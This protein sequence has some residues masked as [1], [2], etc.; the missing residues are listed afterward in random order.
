MRGAGRGEVRGARRAAA[1]A[2]ARG[3]L[4]WTR[5]GGVGEKRTV[6]GWADGARAV[7]ATGGDA[8]GDREREERREVRGE[9][10]GAMRRA[11]RRVRDGGWGVFR[12]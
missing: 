12:G 9:G 4:R 11:V 5:T 3:G 1:D 10:R 7:R 8:R 2:S 6:E